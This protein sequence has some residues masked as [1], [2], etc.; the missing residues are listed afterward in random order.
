MLHLH[1]A[2]S[3]FG[4]SGITVH[5]ADPAVGIDRANAALR[6]AAGATLPL[7]ALV[8][9]TGT[10][11]APAAAP[12]DG[13]S[14]VAVLRSAADAVRLRERLGSLP[15]LP[16]VG[17]G[18]IGLEV[19]ADR[20]RHGQ[21]V[22]VLESAPRLLLRSVSPELAEHVL[23]VHR[24]SGI[25]VRLGVAVGGFEAVGD[26]LCGAGRGRRAA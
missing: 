18:F 9:A 8:L 4:E 25:D 19:A 6:A 23:Q 26:R 10:R 21:A 24:A 11:A 1:R 2:E 17:G 14:N 7:R 22:E 12:P 15:A 3:W 5:R 20:A 13:L 16:V